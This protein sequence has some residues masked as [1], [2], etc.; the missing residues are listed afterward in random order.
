MPQLWQVVR[1]VWPR[2]MVSWV[3]G[4]DGVNSFFL[5]LVVVGL[6]RRVVRRLKE[7]EKAG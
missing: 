1:M 3:S 7:T 4:V 5:V 6:E 2:S